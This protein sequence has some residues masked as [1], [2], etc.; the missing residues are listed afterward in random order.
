MKDNMKIVVV[1]DNHGDRDVL[2]KIYFANQ[3]ADL[4]LHCG[5]SQLFPQDIYQFV[6]VQG[7]CDYPNTFK[8]FRRI[9]TKW[10]DIFM[11]HGLKLSRIGINYAIAQDCFIYLYG[12]THCHKLQQLENGTYLVNP[13]STSR[14]RDGTSGTYLVII[15]SDQKPEFIFKEVE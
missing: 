1:S 15:L 10:G 8:D 9:K 12:H 6:S 11:E 2:D 7:N 14:P 13:G 3:D 4:F 5:D